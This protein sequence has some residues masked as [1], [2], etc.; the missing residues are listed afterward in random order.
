MGGERGAR[1]SCSPK[2]DGNACNFLPKSRQ[3][4]LLFP[5]V[6]CKIADVFA[7][8][9]EWFKEHDWKSCD[10][11]D[12]SG[13]SNPLL[14]A[15]KTRLLAGFFVAQRREMRKSVFT[16]VRAPDMRKKCL[17]AIA[18]FAMA[19][20]HEVRSR[21]RRSAAQERKG[22]RSRRRRFR[23]AAEE[24]PSLRQTM[25]I[26]TLIF[27]RGS[28]SFSRTIISEYACKDDLS[29]LLFRVGYGSIVPRGSQ[30]PQNRRRKQLYKRIESRVRI[31]S[32]LDSF[33]VRKLLY[34]LITQ[35][36]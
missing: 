17:L 9:S 1:R 22:V 24:N 32:L 29:N 7:E 25:S 21:R 27:S 23:G 14:C 35:R 34:V 2:K 33:A 19:H 11:G 20:K 8:M 3:K 13:G 6:C 10:G 16:E 28:Y 15:M 12:S 5:R 4:Q 26:R 36:F 31:C 30:R 18:F